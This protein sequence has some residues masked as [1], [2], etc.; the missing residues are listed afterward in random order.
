MVPLQDVRLTLLFEALS[1]KCARVIDLFRSW[2]RDGSATIDLQEFTKALQAMG[3][4]YSDGDMRLIFEH[5]DADGSGLVDYVEL[6]SRL[7]PK[8]VPKQLHKLR[9]DM[10]LRRGSSKLVGITGRKK[11]DLSPGGPSV[12]EQLQTILRD[13]FLKVLDIFRMWDVDDDGTISKKEFAEAIGALGYDTSRDDTDAVFAEFDTDGSGVLD[14]H[15]MYQQL[16]LSRK[17]RRRVNERVSRPPDALVPAAADAKEALSQFASVAEAEAGAGV[18]PP[19]SAAEMENHGESTEPAKV[20]PSAAA[21]Q[22]DNADAS[23]KSD[24]AEPPASL[25]VI[26]G[27]GT[28]KEPACGAVGDVVEGES[29]AHSD[30]VTNAR[31]EDEGE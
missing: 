20:E 9:T 31:P 19:A 10:Q 15:E 18:E 3:M 23:S 13:N 27:D 16:R 29:E 7:R 1:R 8:A 26:E 11:L 22:M 6:N 28:S 24:N 12:P 17:H 30:T 25:A 4:Q 5:L 21:A 14:Y 2:D